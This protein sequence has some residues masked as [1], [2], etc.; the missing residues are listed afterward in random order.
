MDAEPESSEERRSERSA[1]LDDLAV[2]EAMGAG[3]PA[4]NAAGLP[5][6]GAVGHGHALKILALAGAAGVVLLI[7]GLVLGILAYDEKY[8]PDQD[9][10]A[11][12]RG[13]LSDPDPVWEIVSTVGFLLTVVGALLIPAVIIGV[14]IVG[15]GRLIPRA[16]R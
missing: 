1:T 3:S 16:K 5:S 13:E 7:A 10:A 2:R 14:L 6:L 4:G 15:I 12:L 9:P 11:R 8:F